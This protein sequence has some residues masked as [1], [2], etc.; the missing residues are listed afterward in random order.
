M[1][2]GGWREGELSQAVPALVDPA[3]TNFV[4]LKMH[5]P[6][7]KSHTRAAQKRGGEE[8]RNRT[9]CLHQWQYQCKPQGPG[10]PTHSS[11]GGMI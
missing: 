5:T 6:S 7:P 3:K 8:G 4:T 9:T 1:D 2:D 10:M 11:G